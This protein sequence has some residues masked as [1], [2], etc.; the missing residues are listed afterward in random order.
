MAWTLTLPSHVVAKIRLEFDG[1][2]LDGK[3]CWIWAGAK[4]S[5][6]YG[7]TWD[8][9][10]KRVVLAHRHVYELLN[11]PIPE[12]LVIDHRCRVEVC[13]NP[14]HLEPVTQGE[15]VRRGRSGQPQAEA[16]AART[17]CAA[18]HD[19]AVHGRTYRAADRPSGVRRVCREC[20]NIRQRARRA[21]HN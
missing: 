14:W 1:V 2:M 8:R 6:G 3:G 17:H 7:E 21:G 12:G 5:M 18:G 20:L 9:D 10:A 13:V 19:Y 11:G 4:Q 15:N 16:A